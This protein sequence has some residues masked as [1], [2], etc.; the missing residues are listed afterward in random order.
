MAVLFRFYRIIYGDPSNPTLDSET[1]GKHKCNNMRESKKKMSEGVQHL[2]FSF[3]LIRERGQK[4]HY[5][6]G[7]GWGGSGIHYSQKI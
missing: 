5:K 2:F 6:R 1:N 3:E 4:Y 7:S